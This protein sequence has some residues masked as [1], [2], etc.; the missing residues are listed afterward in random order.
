M[1]NLEASEYT[2]PAKK[3]PR[4]KDSLRGEVA[5]SKIARIFEQLNADDLDA[6][7]NYVRDRY[8]PPATH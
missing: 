5:I 4:K 6:V 3:R 8:C 1:S 2:E 7:R